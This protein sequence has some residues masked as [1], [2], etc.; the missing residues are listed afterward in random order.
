M[1]IHKNCNL[2]FAVPLGFSHKQCYNILYRIYSKTLKIR[3]NGGIILKQAIIFDLDGTL[4]DTVGS[5]AEAGNAMLT[6]RGWQA[7]AVDAYRYFAGDG[8]KALV[9]RALIAAGDNNAEQSLPEALAQY[10]EIFAE[11]CTHGVKPFDGIPELLTQ[12]KE[13][14]VRIAVLSNKPHPMTVDVV[15]S[16]FGESLFDVVQGQTADIPP[17]PDQTG[18]QHILA[19]LNLHAEDC[20][21]VGDTDTDMDTGRNAS[22]ETVGVLWGF[23]G[24]EELKAHHADHIISHPLQ[25]LELL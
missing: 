7:Q 8:A 14:G 15:H 4:T 17:K 10:M 16:F 25:L 23:R 22:M 3:L 5:I 13:R 19:Q 1:T 18:V 21:Y 12:L 6:L 20:L 11:T 9:L 24:E 2:C